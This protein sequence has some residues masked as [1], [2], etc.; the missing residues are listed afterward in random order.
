MGSILFSSEF[1]FSNTFCARF[2]ST[3]S[4]G[5]SILD[6][7]TY[8][9]CITEH[10]ASAN[11]LLCRVYLNFGYSDDAQIY[12]GMDGVG[13]ECRMMKQLSGKWKFVNTQH[14]HPD[15]RGFHNR[16]RQMPYDGL[17]GILEEDVAFF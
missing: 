14:W 8:L 3:L 12:D 4:P 16:R 6:C 9:E 15:G 1:P 2:D 7:S 11:P 17:P 10:W 13:V 5:M